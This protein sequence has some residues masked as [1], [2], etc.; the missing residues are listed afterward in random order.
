[1]SDADR[2]GAAAGESTRMVS[3]SGVPPK[4]STRSARSRT[5]F[6][7][8]QFQAAWAAAAEAELTP[9]G[10]IQHHL[11]NLT[12]QVQEG[13][14]WTLHVDTL[15]T[16]VLMGLVGAGVMGAFVAYFSTRLRDIYFSITTLVFAG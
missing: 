7:R 10:Y 1:M 8:P 6:G 3:I 12:F 13:G 14:F 2:T 5:A 11:K 9:T 16:A 15:V 4:L